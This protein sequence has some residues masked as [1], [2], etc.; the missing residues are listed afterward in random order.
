MESYVFEQL[1]KHTAVNFH[2][3]SFLL[4]LC[5][6][7]DNDNDHCCRQYKRSVRSVSSFARFLNK[8]DFPGM[9]FCA[10]ACS[11]ESAFGASAA[12]S[13]PSPTN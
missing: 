10:V 11:S 8:S 13:Q 5:Q 6:D 9:R 4:I 1:P 3:H 12:E 2:S 7:D